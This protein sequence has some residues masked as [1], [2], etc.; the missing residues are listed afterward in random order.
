[1]LF[2]SEP[3]I[4]SP[5]VGIHHPAGDFKRIS[6]GVRDTD[7]LIRS[8]PKANFYTIRWSQG[9]TEGGS[10]GSPIFNS[11][12]QV[13]GTLSHGPSPPKGQTVCDIEPIDFYGR[14]SVQ[15]RTLK[16]F[17]EPGS[18][19]STNPPPAPTQ[20]VG[21]TLVSGQARTFSLQPVT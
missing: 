21:G 17:L 12:R 10:S 20:Q 9:R 15:Y 1:M 5:L 2:R 6:T 13:V 11:R 8:V 14:F 4:G 18:G 19:G 16:R 7:D 3:A